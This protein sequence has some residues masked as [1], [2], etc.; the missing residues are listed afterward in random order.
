MN[1]IRSLL[2]A[3]IGAG[4]LGAALASSIPALAADS[5]YSCTDR[6]GG[7]SSVM[8]TLTA[9]RT[10]HHD[11]YDRIVFEFSGASSLP[12]Y[13]LTRQSSSTF[14]EDA[15]GRPR[16][17]EGSAGVRSVFHG[18]VAS[19]SAPADA[20]PELPV[21]R[22]VRQIGN[23]E[24]VTSYG[25]GLSR[26]ACFKTLELTGPARLVVDFQTPADS[27]SSSAG[28]TG[29]TG[30]SSGNQGSPVVQ[31]TTIAGN[32]V[33]SLAQTGHPAATASSGLL[34]KGDLLMIG[35]AAVLVVAAGAVLAGHKL[36]AAKVGH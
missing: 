13:S 19:A 30:S 26:A 31:P 4:A 24:R 5:S 2:T 1:P 34:D 8:A 17:L 21:I 3:L 20:K 29:Q 23:F 36:A 15:S 9:V 35:L 10:A 6:S 22:E 28:S 12:A 11:G 18:T 32:S 7:S 14:T 33:D 25:I 27:T 16:T